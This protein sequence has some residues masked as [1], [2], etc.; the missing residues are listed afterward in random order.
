MLL[1]LLLLLLSS[2]LITSSSIASLMAFLGQKI[3]ALM[4]M[5]TSLLVIGEEASFGESG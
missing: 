1:F 3:S 4:V 5:V 2:S